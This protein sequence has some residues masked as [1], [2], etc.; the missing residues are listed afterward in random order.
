MGKFKAPENISALD[1]E[2]L[3]AAIEEALEAF[4]QFDDIADEDVSDDQAEE[5]EAIGKFVQ[6][7]NTE[8]TTRETAAAERKQRIADLRKGVKDVVGEDEGDEGEGDEGTEGADEG[9]TEDA[10]AEE[11]VEEK[12]PVA[13]S[14]KTDTASSKR[15]VT[16]RAARRNKDAAKPETAPRMT[17]TAS[18]DVPGFAAGHK[19]ETLTA[20]GAAIMARLRALPT[21]GKAVVRTSALNFSLPDQKLSQEHFQRDTELLLTASSESRL[22]GGSLTA[23]GGWGAP[24]DT[25]LD[26]CALETTEG[27]IELPEVT[28]TRGGVNY[29]KGPS[30]ASVLGSAT[31]FWDMTEAVAEAGTELK[32]SLR[33]AVPPFIDKRLDAVGVMM[34]AGLLLRA[35]WPELVDRYAQMALAAHQMKIH[36]KVLAGVR[37][38]TGAAVD[39]TGVGFGNA[40]D[41][42]HILELV[43][44]GER[45]RNFMS[46]SQTLEVLLPAWLVN[47]IRADLANRNGVVD[48]LSITNEQINAHFTARNLRVQW[49]NGYQEI[50]LTG[51][52]QIATAYPATVEA[53]MYPAGTYVKGVA[54]VITLDTIYDSVNLKKNDYVHLFVEQGVTV[55]NPCHDGKRVSFPLVA[56]GRTGAANLTKDFGKAVI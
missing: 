55:T 50:D 7:A 3:E 32:T 24:S 44:A 51:P 49:L 35:G 37:A 1:N 54:D 40:T 20:A 33:P 43:A 31:G 8:I 47:V 10:P 12:I 39:L 25:L 41:A 15:T 17:L 26:F 14:S 5:M 28:I 42:L 34:E 22:K 9:E 45:Q 27:L 30:F 4:R 11:V 53:I 19:F 2:A 13:A 36:A 56:N 38:Y 16:T 29:T 23:A 52:G 21:Q 6:A 48:A 18:A 46:N